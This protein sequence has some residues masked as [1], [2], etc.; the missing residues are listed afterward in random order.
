MHF[1]VFFSQNVLIFFLFLKENI[2][3]GCSLEAIHRNASNEYIQLI[4]SLKKKKKKKIFTSI[5]MDTSIFL[6]WNMLLL[7]LVRLTF[8]FFRHCFYALSIFFS[9]FRHCLYALPLGAN[10]FLLEYTSFQR[11]SIKQLYLSCLP[12]K[13]ISSPLLPYLDWIF[14]F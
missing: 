9:F 4:F 10:S 8:S 11:E 2:C 12:W 3:C 1:F 5:W 7:I 13:C 14:F 6:L